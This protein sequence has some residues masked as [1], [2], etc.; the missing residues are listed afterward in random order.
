MTDINVS[1]CHLQQ[2]IEIRNVPEGKRNKKREDELL[3]LLIVA[4][5]KANPGL[6]REIRSMMERVVDGMA[7]H[8]LPTIV[9]PCTTLLTPQLLREHVVDA[10]HALQAPIN[11]PYA[12]N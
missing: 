7:P 10:L 8:L 11:M 5:Q 6:D 9:D 12:Q 4:M 3:E 1:L 2:L